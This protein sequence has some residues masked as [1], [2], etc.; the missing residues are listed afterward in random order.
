MCYSYYNVN[1]II[2]ISNAQ[3]STWHKE[4]SQLMAADQKSPERKRLEPDQKEWLWGSKG[5]L[6]CDFFNSTLNP[7]QSSYAA[8]LKWSLNQT[9]LLTS[10]V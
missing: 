5:G 3:D 4:D 1:F 2:Y 8:R 10:W 6:A 9:D 7:P